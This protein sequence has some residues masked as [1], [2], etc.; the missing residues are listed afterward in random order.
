MNPDERARQLHDKATRRTLLTPAEQ[1][2]LQ[3]WNTGKT[4]KKEPCSR[5]DTDRKKRASFDREDGAS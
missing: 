5:N 4:N 1:A 3:E 2:Q